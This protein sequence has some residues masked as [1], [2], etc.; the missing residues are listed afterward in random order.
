MKKLLKLLTAKTFDNIFDTM[1][2]MVIII[3]MVCCVV[4]MIT[5]VTLTVRHNEPYNMIIVSSI[6]MACLSAAISYFF[7]DIYRRK[8]P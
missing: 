4:L 2:A 5:A 1:I 7:I 8:N 6:L 3:A